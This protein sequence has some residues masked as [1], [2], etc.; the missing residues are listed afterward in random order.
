MIKD[1]LDI[2]YSGALKYPNFGDRLNYLSLAKKNYK[3][4]RQFSN[5]FYHSPQ[6]RKLRD[7]IIARDSGYDLGVP[8]VEI[9]GDIF[10]HH[11][12]PIEESDIEEWNE[13]ILL[14]PEYLI[15]CSHDTH[16]AIH[17]KGCEELGFAERHP[18]D[19]KLW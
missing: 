9:E 6:W 3:S 10:V 11:I 2:S 15:T 8:G 4:P 13:D 5:P 14:N 7:E 1:D 16:M 19:T 18:G 12:I 17:Y